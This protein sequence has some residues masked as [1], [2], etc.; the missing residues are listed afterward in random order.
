M[1]RTSGSGRAS[2]LDRRVCSLRA[3]RI[4]TY[5]MWARLS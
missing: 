4:V 3:R 5:K 1:Q 2:P